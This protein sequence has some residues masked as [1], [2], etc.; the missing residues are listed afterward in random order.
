MAFC[1]DCGANIPEGKKFCTGCGKPVTGAKPPAQESAQA[2]AVHT[3]SPVAAAVAAPPIVT[4]V[5]PAPITPVHADEQPPLQGSP[6]AVISTGGFFGSIILMNIPIIG[7]LICII[8]A[9]G[10]CKN[11]NRRNFA[12][13]NLIFLAIWA[14]LALTGYL[15]MN[16]IVRL[17]VD[18]FQQFM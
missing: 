6:Y 9:C 14:V 2:A 16:W 7:W 13:A 3:P 11:R 1:N 17:I 8:W 15:M 4:P 10:G 5:Q 12:R 18:Y